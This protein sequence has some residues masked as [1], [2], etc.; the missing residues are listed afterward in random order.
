MIKTKQRQYRNNMHLSDRTIETRT[1]LDIKEGIP[2]IDS[3]RSM[4]FTV[5]TSS[6]ILCPSSSLFYVIPNFINTQENI[7]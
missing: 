6:L 5:F 1:I 2:N 7:Q 4:N 3:R